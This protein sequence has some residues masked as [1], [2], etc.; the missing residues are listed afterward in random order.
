MNWRHLS[1]GETAEKLQCSICG[2]Q[3][4]IWFFP[5]DATTDEASQLI[6]AVSEFNPSL[7]RADPWR[8]IFC[9]ECQQ[10]LV[11]LSLARTNPTQQADILPFRRQSR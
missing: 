4:A 9:S 1:E 10:H 8:F 7:R 3:Q 2:S 6:A 11:E 5:Q